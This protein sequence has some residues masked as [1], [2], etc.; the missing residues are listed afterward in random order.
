MLCSDTLLPPDNETI[1]GALLTFV[2]KPKKPGRGL[3]AQ[4]PQFH[5]LSC[6]HFESFPAEVGLT[7][8]P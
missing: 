5:L 6:S 7:P 3:G 4:T 8:V 1:S 2:L